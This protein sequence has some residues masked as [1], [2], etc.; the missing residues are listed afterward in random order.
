MGSVKADFGCGIS[1]IVVVPYCATALG[2]RKFHLKK[3][4]VC[5]CQTEGYWL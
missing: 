5:L 3:Q 1:C 2:I 4:G